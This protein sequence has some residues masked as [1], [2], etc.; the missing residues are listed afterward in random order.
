[1]A[2]Q[3]YLYFLHKIMDQI[4]K[5]YPSTPITLLVVDLDYYRVFSSDALVKLNPNVEDDLPETAN[6]S[7]PLI[8]V[9]VFYCDGYT[10]HSCGLAMVAPAYVAPTLVEEEAAEGI[11]VG[12]QCKKIHERVSLVTKSASQISGN[13][14]KGRGRLSGTLSFQHVP[15][16]IGLDFTLVSHYHLAIICVFP[17]GQLVSHQIRHRKYK[18]QVMV[19]DPS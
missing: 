11:N 5:H 18:G 14:G 16:M 3:D 6:S 2:V 17:L 13:E 9:R 15:I 10:I 12:T 1:M 7:K 8:A 19:T 4:C